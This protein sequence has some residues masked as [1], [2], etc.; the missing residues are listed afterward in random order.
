M[1]FQESITLCD[2]GEMMFALGSSACAQ[3]GGAALWRAWLSVEAAM[4]DGVGQALLCRR[5]RASWQRAGVGAG[6]HRNLSEGRRTQGRIL[7]P[8]PCISSK[9]VRQTIRAVK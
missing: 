1:I 7:S 2:N 8:L 9:T 4:V 3:G 5:R 6:H